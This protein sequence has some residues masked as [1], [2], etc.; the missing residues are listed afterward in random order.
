VLEAVG[1]S[2]LG[3]SSLLL[4]AA[5][6]FVLPIGRRTLGLIMGFGAGVLVSA[7]AYEL[8]E[9]S[10]AVAIDGIA[11]AAGFASGALGF[12]AGDVLIDRRI[13][14]RSGRGASTGLAIVLGAVLD[15]IPESVV[16]GASLLTG[17]HASVAVIV[18][19][20]L[21]N[22][23][24]AIAA[25]N[26]LG[27]GGWSTR[28]IVLLWSVVLITSALA[29]GIGYVALEN[30]SGDWIA[31]IQAFA[32]GAI[33]TMLTDE[34][35]PEAFEFVDRDKSVGLAVALGFAVAAALSFTN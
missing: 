16:I 10:I 26:E 22:I 17:E 34:M 27:R 31:A 12:Y 9:E 2:L 30:K 4:G 28:S 15:G 21:S 23:P 33:L 13:T 11:V 6:S 35:F 18:A 25:S 3:A 32:A 20:F 24:E 19:V 1:W 29:A 8:V 14:A 5:A 7:V